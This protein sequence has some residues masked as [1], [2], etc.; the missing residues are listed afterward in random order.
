[1]AAYRN[2]F[3]IKEEEDGVEARAGSMQNS[4]PQDF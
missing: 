2:I 3:P 1:M 4:E